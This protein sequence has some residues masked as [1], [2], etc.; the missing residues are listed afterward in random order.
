MQRKLA[1]LLCSVMLIAVFAAG[2]GGDQKASTDAGEEAK[3]ETKT[4]LEKIKERGKVIVGVNNQLPGFGYLDPNGEYTGFD[5][6][7]G[8]ALAA[9]IFGDPNAVEFRPLSDQRRF[10]AL[11]MGEIDVLIRNTTWTIHRDTAL[12]LN[13]GPTTFYDGQGMLVRKDSGINSLKD[14]D[15]KRIGV[16]AGTTTELNL[17]DYIRKLGISAEVVT[18]DNVDAVVAAYKEGS[19]DA[20]T[21]DKSAL[22]SRM[23]TLSNPDEHK[24]LPETMS[25]EPL[26][27][28]VRE[29]D[30][31][32]FDIVTWVVFATIQAEEFGIT[33]QNIDEFLQSE[34][35]SIKRFLGLEGNFGEN[36]G[37]ENDFV[38]KVIRNVGNYGE[39][40]DRHLGPDT[41]FGLERGINDLWTNGG[42]M[43]PPPFR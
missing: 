10:T 4:T 39:I 26:G 28:V 3:V 41:V 38:V 7:F 2:C 27:P 32:W 29:G 5:V 40:F 35:P 8:R 14:L 13:F 43:Y 9:A 19:V 33:S 25:K 34:D 36:L 12:G 15:G 18:F 22:L 42:L 31:Q 6:D 23:A 21:S 17:T 30:D 20:W 16:L 11:Q 24:I 37:L 1:L